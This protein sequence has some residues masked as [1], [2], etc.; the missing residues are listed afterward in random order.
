[1]RDAHANRSFDGPVHVQGILAL[2]D[3]RAEDGGFF[4][5]PGSHRVIRGWAHA[6]P[7]LVGKLTS[8]E[9]SSN[10][11][12]PPGDTLR[13]SG[14]RVP[15]RAGTVCIWDARTAHCNYA[16][17]SDRLRMVQ[18]LQMKRADDPAL[19]PLFTDANMLPPRAQFELSPLGAKLHGLAPWGAA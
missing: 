12:L 4:C 9:S 6:H 13:A 5:V 19:G 18:Y 17:D 11:W 8:P 1:M 2:C 3:C 16:N 10:I 14:Q 15:L 7:E